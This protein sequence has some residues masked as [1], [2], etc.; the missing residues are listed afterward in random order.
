MLDLTKLL[1]DLTGEATLE[2][3][4]G[5]AVQMFPCS[6]Q[7]FGLLLNQANGLCVRVL[8]CRTFECVSVHEGCEPVGSIQWKKST[9]ALVQHCSLSLHKAQVGFRH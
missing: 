8:L 6:F 9:A 4:G 7:S 5:N 2:D 3:C 1:R